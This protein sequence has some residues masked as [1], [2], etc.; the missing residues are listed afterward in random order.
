MQ[1]FGVLPFEL[2]GEGDPPAGDD[3]NEIVTKALD[4]LRSTIDERFT[5]LE[6]KTT[7][8]DK[9]GKR[10]D[11]IETKIARPGAIKSPNTDEQGKIETKA[12]LGYARRGIER[13]SADEVK[14][15]TVAGD[16]TTAGYLAPSQFAAEL[17][18]LLVQYSPIRQYARVV[19]IGSSSV[20]YPR[21]TSSTAAVWVDETE[22]R[23]E[24]HP[25]YEQV[26]LTP[27]ELAT[28]TDIST[29][30]LEDNAYN[31]E[32]ELAADF[33]ESFGKTEGA[34][35]VAG[36]GTGK[37][38]GIIAASGIT[39]VKTGVAADFPASNPADKILDLFHALPAP[40]AQNAVWIMNRTTLGT[41]RKW[42]DGQGRY[43]AVDPITA[44]AP[45][46][47]LGRP[48]VEAIDMDSVGA[49]KFPILFG[50]LSGYR[51]VDR[52]SLSV[53]RDPYSLATKGQVRF[54]ARK[55]VGADVTHPDRFV[56][57]QCAV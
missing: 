53:L 17:L 27:Y 43:L 36:D 22:D 5:A 26:T 29:Q 23:T 45:V 13:L 46:T 48:V 11:A 32:G 7:D 12:F 9:F 35:F 38:K 25:A 57:L 54:H 42:K 18:K 30:L 19:T 44:G 21:R 15:L 3:T 47:L 10:L 16:G 33:A 34:A 20:K 39:V 4:G 52:V 37:P 1:D 55:R 24:S 2:K 31:L 41:V 49:N 56:K 28:F 50:D 40:H 14:A 6:S 51:I 8:F